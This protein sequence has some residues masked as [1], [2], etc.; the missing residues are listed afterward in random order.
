MDVDPN[1]PL[2]RELDRNLSEAEERLRH[3]ELVAPHANVDLWRGWIAK[4]R[5]NPQ[6]A[7]A[8][9]AQA[10]KAHPKSVST[11]TSYLVNLISQNTVTG[12][13]ADQTV[14][15]ASRFPNRR[16]LRLYAV[17]F[18]ATNGTLTPRRRCNAPRA[19]Q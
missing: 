7:A 12:E 3:V 15:L 17:A 4:L 19:G 1:Q 10:V 13:L 5:G 6:K 18:I 2:T 11:A 9:F 14:P 8:L 16:K